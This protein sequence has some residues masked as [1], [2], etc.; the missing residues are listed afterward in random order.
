MYVT[1]CFRCTYLV[2]VESIYSS[3]V[4]ATACRHLLL[5]LWPSLDFLRSRS[6]VSIACHKGDLGYLSKRNA[7]AFVGMTPNQNNIFEINSHRVWIS[8]WFSF[9][10][11]DRSI[12]SYYTNEDVQSAR[13]YPVWW[14]AT[15]MAPR[16][17]S[18]SCPGRLRYDIRG[19]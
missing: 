11:S 18:C 6:L 7:L 3:S 13:E 2:S 9:S 14:A 10:Y 16:V 12:F 15:P 19:V 8:F 17:P 5:W 4:R 1:M